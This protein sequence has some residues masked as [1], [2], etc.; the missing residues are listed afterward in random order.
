MKG[1]F[2]PNWRKARSSTNQSGIHQ[3]CIDTIKEIGKRHSED[4]IDFDLEQLEEDV[5][6]VCQF[7]KKF[8]NNRNIQRVSCHA[9]SNIAIDQEKC[10]L[11]TKLVKFLD[12]IFLNFVFVFFGGFVEGKQ[13]KQNCQLKYKTTVNRELINL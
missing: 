10:P 5:K 4:K 12:L 6:I 1:L 2:L 13:R 9:I 3:N 11:V 7:M 8:V